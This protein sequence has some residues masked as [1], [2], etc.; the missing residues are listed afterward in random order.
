M[1][2][3]RFFTLILFLLLTNAAFA[4]LSVSNTQQNTQQFP[5]ASNG[6]VCGI[7][8]DNTENILVNKAG[9]FLAGDIEMVTGKKP[10]VNKGFS[11][12]GK[13]VVIIG[14]I[15]KSKLIADLVKNKKINID[16]INGRWEGFMIQT[17]RKPFPG[18]EK[19]L[20]IVGSDR[21]GAA[22]GTFTVSESIGVSPWYWWADVPVKQNGQIFMDEVRYVSKGPAVKYRGIFIND[23]SPA[24]R[25]WA[26]EKF[27]GINH[28][29]YEKIFELLLRQKANFLWPSMW[30]PTMFNVDDPLNPKTADEFGIVM[31]TSH[32]EPMM[33]AHN[34]WSLFNGGAW[35]YTTNKKKLQEFW[36]G[37]IKRMGN[38]ES[39]VT[40]GMR[41]DGDAGMSEETAVDLLKEIIK[42]QREIIS[43]VTGKPAETVPQVWAIYKEVQDYY[44]KGMRVDDDITVLFSDDNWG[45]IRYL[46]KKEPQG[47]KKK[48]GMYYHV[49][50]VGAPYHTDGK[51]LPR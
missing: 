9:H 48:Y 40:V 3:K 25:Y 20:V 42:D 30:L 50:Y 39:V 7:Y 49:D 35:D 23:E 12:P 15:G 22:F 16:E 47:S 29:C 17:V 18:V 19:A 5:L 28:Q 46:P 2:N 36:H 41:G 43:D 31:S 11:N 34:E 21:R 8:V 38:Y 24:F 44:D 33:R 6:M 10:D 1:K 4:Q 26:F 45:N 32:H 37:G 51:M 14:T 13:N 27:G